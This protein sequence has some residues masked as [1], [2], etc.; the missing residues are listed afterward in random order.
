M[1]AKTYFHLAAYRGSLVTASVNVALAGVNDA[2]LTRDA[3]SN[4]LAPGGMRIRLG[5][6][7]GV[8]ISRSRINTASLREVALPY[9]A[10]VNN[11]LTVPTPPNLADFGDYGP[12]PRAADSISIETTHSDAATQ[13]MYALLWMIFGRKEP[14]PGREYRTRFTGAITAVAGT[15][16]SG[17]MTL[18]QVL[19]AGI[20]QVVGMDVFGTNLLAARL[21]FVG[22]GWR[23]GVLAR[24]TVSGVPHPIFTDGRLGV[25]GE[26]NS[27]AMPQ[28][29]IYAEAANSV[30]EGYLDLVRVGDYAPVM[31]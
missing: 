22:G 8:N 30:Q 15:W 6:T 9:I 4:F 21:A 10:P 2:A 27:V 5:A 26:F 20:Y 25:F 17:A 13:V 28:L 1:D 11:G 23:P 16:V 12:T 31:M 19:P 24:P 14:T 7:G 29:E 3:S 18:D